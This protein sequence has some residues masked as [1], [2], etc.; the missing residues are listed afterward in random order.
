[1]GDELLDMKKAFT[2]AELLIAL[3]IVGVVAILTVPHVVKNA[4]TRA[5]VAV[6][7]QTY[8]KVSET[9]QSLMLEERIQI[10]DDLDLPLSDEDETQSHAFMKKY[11][12]ISKDCGDSSSG[13][14]AA[15]YKDIEDGS[16][17]GDMFVKN[18]SETFFVLA[19]GAAVALTA[20]I[21]GYLYIDVN[22]VEAPNVLGRD[23]FV[24]YIDQKGAV[25]ADSDVDGSITNIAEDCKSFEGYWVSCFEYLQSNNW[26]MDY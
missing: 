11:F 7:Q 9:L 25:S 17:R 26:K 14:F 13:C 16:S 20:D 21:A 3:T 22:N 8:T 4:F 19:N 2:L 1:M 24:L 6:L 12:D 23:L 10:L 18:D 5:N 15:S